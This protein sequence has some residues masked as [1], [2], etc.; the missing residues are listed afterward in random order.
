MP[1]RSRIR[2]KPRSTSSVRSLN[3]PPRV[4][5]FGCCRPPDAPHDRRAKATTPRG[6]ARKSAISKDDHQAPPARLAMVSLVGDQLS[7]ASG[8]G[9]ASTAVRCSM[10]MAKVPAGS[11]YRPLARG[12][13]L[14]SDHRTIRSAACGSSDRSGG[15]PQPISSMGWN[16]RTS[17]RVL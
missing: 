11:Q 5:A 3:L 14:G 6:A 13:H 17:P 16:R 8:V 12:I 1:P 10:A 7:G 4:A 2:A 15:N 9:A